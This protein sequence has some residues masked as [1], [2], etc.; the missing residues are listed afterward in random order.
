MHTSCREHF[1]AKDIQFVAET[2]ADTRA[3]RRQLTAF[4]A[5]PTDRDAVLDNDRLLKVLLEQPQPISVSAQFYFYML[6]RSVLKPYGRDIT[7]YVA[8]VL[9]S[10]VKPRRGGVSGTEI[11]T[12]AFYVT[13]MLAALKAVPSEQAYFIRAQIGDRALFLTGIFPQHLKLRAQSRGAPDI[14]FFEQVGSASYRQASRH[15]LARENA[16]EEVYRVIADQFSEVR[17][18]LNQLGDRLICLEPAGNP[19]S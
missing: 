16:L 12:D 6:S 17:Q 7:D 9:V 1:S 8:S 18:C 5:E 2:L 14:G 11:D 10:F 13:D 4:L 19:L 3:S 15:R